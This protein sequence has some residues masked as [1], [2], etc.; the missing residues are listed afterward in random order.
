LH[1]GHDLR[2]RVAEDE[3]PPG[4]HVVDIDIAVDIIDACSGST[5]HEGRLQIH[6]F[7]GPHRA[8]YT[9]RNELLRLLKE[10]C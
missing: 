3:G 1:G 10:G 6:R 5:L 4:S 2:M 9:A 8:V 7:K